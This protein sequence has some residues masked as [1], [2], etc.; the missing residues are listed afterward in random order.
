ML[1]ME[2]LQ[3]LGRLLNNLYLCTGIKFA[4]MD[5][6]AREIYTSS[7]QTP[8]CRLI[9]NEED[10]YQRCVHCD[11]LALADVKKQH[12]KK[13]YLCH[14]GLYELAMPVT[15]GG[16]TI[17]I[18]LCGQIL[19]DAPRDEQWQRV[20][21]RCGW[22]PDQEALHQAF[23]GLK[24]VSAEQM[25]ACMEI[26]QACVSEVRL[27]GLQAEESRDDA[28][29]LQ[30]YIETH[31]SEALNAD[32]L[33]RALNVGKTKLFELCRERFGSTPN[34][35]ITQAR[36]AVAKDLLTGTAQSVR[37]IAQAVGIP[38]ENYFAKVFKKATGTTPR[39]FRKGLCL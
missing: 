13:K 37:F 31:Y 26:V 30:S 27:Y 7:Y 20:A 11:D 3:R 18:I 12:V 9:A 25:N 19:D 23:L 14:A 33:C 17:A 22:Y 35:L 29:R 24:R 6:N 10:G 5:D 28:L 8:F 15:E 16:R 38:D 1:T 39:A 21:T 34:S 4:I 2:S 32:K 36:I